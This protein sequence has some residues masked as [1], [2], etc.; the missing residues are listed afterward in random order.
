MERCKARRAGGMGKP[1]MGE[2]RARIAE[3]R[4]KIGDCRSFGHRSQILPHSALC[5]PHSRGSATPSRQRLALHLR[6]WINPALT[7]LYLGTLYPWAVH[8]PISHNQQ[9]ITIE[10]PMT[11]IHNADPNHLTTEQLAGQR[12]MVGFEGKVLDDE[13]RFLIRELHVGG[14]VLFKRNVSDPARL[15]ALCRG[16]QAYA[17]E[18]GHPPLLI[19]IDQE[20]GPVA[21]LG[22]PFTVF[23]GHRAIGD[24]GSE[25][26]AREFGRITARELRSVG[27]NV[28]FAPVVDLAPPGFD[29]VMA[30]RV[31]GEDPVLVGS[32]AGV[33]IGA[34]QEGGVAATAKHFPGIGRTTLDSH[35]DLP[36]LDEKR[37][38]MESSD[39]VPFG[40]AIAS[41]V[42]AV[43][44]SHVIYTDIDPQWPASLSPAIARDLL[45]QAMGFG[46]VVV[47]DDLDMGAI[48]NHFD[49]ETVVTQV[50]DSG[51]DIVLICR[52]REKMVN[53]HDALV[54]A[55][56]ASDA[57]KARARLSVKRLLD[58]KRKYVP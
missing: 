48:Q 8:R 23:P 9:P 17:L 54:R 35:L 21:R 41:R 46:G 25:E 5:N 15:S 52:D 19:S 12:L 55:V 53:A 33:V 34:L 57:E 4:R 47:T 50:L 2:P 30:D 31:F 38:V 32:L 13:L 37:A 11:R 42:E 22:P 10:Q 29:S 51:I 27:I 7:S 43:M 18:T 16:A 1:L 26:A 24:A 36:F 6:A 39:L 3:G 44:L 14:L 20:G 40:M 49:L 45:R 56:G 28:N 58:L